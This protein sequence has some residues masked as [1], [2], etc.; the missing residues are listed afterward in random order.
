MRTFEW[1]EKKSEANLVKH[2]VSFREAASVF[3]DPF[4]LTASDVLHS[5]AEE[6][7]ITIGLSGYSQVLIVVTTLRHPKLRIISARK[8]TSKERSRYVEAIKKTLGS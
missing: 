8:A 1:S 2:G 3:T 4:A 5:E 7:D 6:R